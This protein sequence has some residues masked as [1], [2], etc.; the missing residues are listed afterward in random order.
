VLV[1]QIDHEHILYRANH[2]RREHN[3][4]TMT[5]TG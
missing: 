4:M 2:L 5:M 1:A 3:L